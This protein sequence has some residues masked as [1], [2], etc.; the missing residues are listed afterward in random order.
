MKTTPSRSTCTTPSGKR[1]SFRPAGICR[2]LC[3]LLWAGML[4]AC[5]KDHTVTVPSNEKPARRTVLI[6]MC[7]QNSLGS[8]NYHH[9]D[10]LEIIAGKSYLSPED[11]LLIYIDDQQPPRIYEVKPS[12]PAPKLVYRW[13][14]DRC[15]TSPAHFQW[16]LEWMKTH[17]QA[18]EYGLVMWSHA[19]GWIPSTHKEGDRPAP[20]TYSFGIDTGEGGKMSSDKDADGKTGIQMDITDMASAIS[21]SGIHFKYI[22]FDACLMQNVE[23]DYALRHVT[24][25]VVASPISISAFGGNYTHLIREG[26]FNDDISDIVTTYHSD[27][28]DPEQAQQYTDYGIVIS[29]VRTAGLEELA[30]LTSELLKTSSV[31]QGTIPDCEDQVLHYH[32]YTYRYYYRPHQYDARCAMRRLLNDSGFKRFE[33]ALDK[34]VVAKKTTPRFWSGPGMFNYTEVDSTAYCGMAM[35]LPQDTYTLHAASCLYGDLNQAFRLT[36][37]CR[38]AGWD[39]LATLSALTP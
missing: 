3:V 34:V 25:Y 5:D 6:Y 15:S 31:I 18:R 39:A 33:E 21:G 1:H 32:P 12:L 10:S 7:A 14:E 35:F 17:F 37:W 11:R 38:D 30:A 29:A 4:A 9:S 24:D 19:D 22:M 8:G 13:N 16:V 36:E 23:S 27:I 26:L 20:S 28:V 2:L